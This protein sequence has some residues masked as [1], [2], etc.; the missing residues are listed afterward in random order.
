M[1][2]VAIE[3]VQAQFTRADDG[4]FPAGI[5]DR[6]PDRYGLDVTWSLAPDSRTLSCKVGFGTIF[7][8]EVVPYEVRAAF[9]LLYELQPGEEL[10]NEDLANFAYWNALF[11][12][13]PYWREYLS[14][15]VNRGHLPQFVAP[16]MGLPRS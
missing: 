8:G 11:N 5:G 13:W 15:T 3:L 2:I 12:A 7:E 16:V 4:F 10:E 6:K 14:S 9:R 1:Q